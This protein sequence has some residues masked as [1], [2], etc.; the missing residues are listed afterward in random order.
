MSKA[1]NILFIMCDQLRADYLSC[2]GHPRLDTP[3]IDA[4]AA[5][6]VLFSHAFCQAPICGGSRMSFYTGRYIFTHGATWNGVALNLGEKTLGDYLRPLDYRVALV[7][8]T[9]MKADV[10]GM[11]RLALIP[12]LLSVFS[13]ANAA[14]NLMREM[15]AC[16]VPLK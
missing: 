10:E 12:I 11:E 2:T 14:S 8:K 9:H 3:N 16:G 4:L 1:K 5:R 13:P 15:M 7:G 6:G